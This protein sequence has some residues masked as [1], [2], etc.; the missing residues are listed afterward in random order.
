MKIVLTGSLGHISKRLAKLL[1]TKGHSVKVVTRKPDKQQDIEAIGAKA[2]IGS[3]EDVAFLTATFQSADIVYLMEPPF[4]FVDSKM[5][6]ETHM[7]NIAHN[8]VQAVQQA[9]ITKVIHLSSVGGH[10]RLQGQRQ[11]NRV[12]LLSWS[13]RISLIYTGSN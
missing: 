1:V 6:P 10:I 11:V 7:L 5:A 3:M 2:A 8:Y 13:M 4:N 12:W 9:G